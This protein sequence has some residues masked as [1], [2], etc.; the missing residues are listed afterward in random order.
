VFP[1]NWKPWST[2]KKQSIL[3][4]VDWS[5]S[6]VRF[7]VP[8]RWWWRNGHVWTCPKMPNHAEHRQRKVV[9]IVR[10]L[11]SSRWQFQQPFSFQRLWQK[12]KIVFTLRY[13]ITID[14]ND[15]A[16]LENFQL[17]CVV[18]LLQDLLTNTLYLVAHSPSD[19]VRK[20]FPLFYSS[21]SVQIVTHVL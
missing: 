20:Y 9:R 5:A 17:K 4:S 19:E 18:K 15:L 6:G 1:K 12:R 10:Q 21:F 16:F 2:L 13:I 7:R 14:R 8:A 3:I 11:H